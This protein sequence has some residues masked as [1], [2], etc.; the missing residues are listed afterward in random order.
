MAQVAGEG[1]SGLEA[2]EGILNDFR[3]CPLR[4]HPGEMALRRRL[5]GSH[6][7]RPDV[8]RQPLPGPGDEQPAATLVTADLRFYNAVKDTPWG[9]HCLWVENVP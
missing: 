7:K 6:R 1:S 9:Q 8:L 5:A 3:R 2:M 4:I